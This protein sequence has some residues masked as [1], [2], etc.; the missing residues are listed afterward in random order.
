MVARSCTNL[1]VNRWTWRENKYLSTSPN[2]FII[3][4]IHIDFNLE[5]FLQKQLCAGPNP[6][7]HKQLRTLNYATNCNKSTSHYFL[8][9]HTRTAK[10]RVKN[11]AVS[12]I[13]IWQILA[14]VRLVQKGTS[15]GF[16]II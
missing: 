2:L 7:Q 5:T 10:V 15:R 1:N 9:V 3:W 8:A 11:T 14:N 4:Y 16:L 13:P 12:F 6:K